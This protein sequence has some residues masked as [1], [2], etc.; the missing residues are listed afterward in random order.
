MKTTVHRPKPGRLRLIR[1]TLSELPS[2][3]DYS[4]VSTAVEKSTQLGEDQISA[5]LTSLLSLPQSTTVFANPIQHQAT[6]TCSEAEIELQIRSFAIR[7]LIQESEIVSGQLTP[8]QL[9]FTG[10]FGQQPQAL[11]DLDQAELLGSLIDRKFFRVTGEKRIGLNGSAT[12]P[13]LVATFMQAYPEAGPE[14]AV[15]YLSTLQKSQRSSRT[16]RGFSDQRH[17]GLFLTQQIAAHMNNVAIGAM[18][19]YMRYQ[20]A[21]K[22]DFPSA[23]LARQTADFITLH[24]DEGKTA[25]QTTYSL[26]LGRKAT[27]IEGRILE[28]MGMIQ[29]HHGS[30]ASNMVARYMASLHTVS[31]SDFFVASQMILDGKRHFGAIHNM[32]SFVREL[33]QLSAEERES[34]IREKVLTGGLPTFGHPEISAAGRGQQIQQDPRA[35]IYLSPLFDAV[36][37]GQIE[38][39]DNQLRSL[40]IV[41]RIYQIVFVEGVVKPGYKEEP[42]LRLTPNTDFGAWCVQEALGIS[43]PDR[44]LLT[45]IFRGFGWIMDGREQLQLKIIRPVIAPDPV[46][47]PDSEDNQTVPNLVLSVHNRLSQTSNAFT[48]NWSI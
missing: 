40:E 36:D 37:S 26:L 29:T 24:Q 28:M 31:I 1:Q 12:I 34:V 27:D 47:I 7:G 45:Y 14:L 46:I 23:E 2:P 32:T 3:S 19:T 18:S 38:L 9:I 6:V 22:P 20:L 13:Y 15:Q 5:T 44:T 48:K 42:P 4:P 17:I 8:A 10:L 35:A 11:D 39:S 21:E 25:F 41:Q 33:E 30:A 43:D 16:D